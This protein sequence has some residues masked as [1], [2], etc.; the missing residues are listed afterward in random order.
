MR[1]DGC[2]GCSGGYFGYLIGNVANLFWRLLLLLAIK[3]PTEVKATLSLYNL[4]I[5]GISH[6]A[7]GLNV[8]K[9]IK[10]QEKSVKFIAV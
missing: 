5:T 9:S 7:K 6:V 8:P 1:W 3:Y 4:N 2:L 10:N